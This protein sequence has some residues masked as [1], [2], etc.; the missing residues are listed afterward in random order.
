MLGSW[1]IKWKLLYCSLKGLSAQ[2][3]GM[4]TNSSLSVCLVIYLRIQDDA[5]SSTKK[6]NVSSYSDDMQVSHSFP[7]PAECREEAKSSQCYVS[8]LED[9]WRL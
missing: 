5:C 4:I 7:K 9:L 8:S 1:R 6:L 2:Q 3:T